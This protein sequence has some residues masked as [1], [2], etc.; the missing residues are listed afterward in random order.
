MKSR[1]QKREE[2]LIRN[3]QWAKIPAIEQVKLL[4]KQGFAAKKQRI[5][6]AKIILN[7]GANHGR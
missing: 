1:T 6:L 7:Q 2:A 4:D 3:A 5:K